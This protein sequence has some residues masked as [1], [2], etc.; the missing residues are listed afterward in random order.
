MLALQGCE[1]AHLHVLRYVL[2]GLAGETC[3]RAFLIVNLFGTTLV[4][5]LNHHRLRLRKILHAVAA[6][7]ASAGRPTHDRRVVELVSLVLHEL[8]QLVL[9]Q[10]VINLTAATQLLASVEHLRLLGQLF[11]C[12]AL[13]ARRIVLSAT[14]GAIGSGS[15]LLH[16]DGVLGGAAARVADLL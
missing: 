4:V 9:V 16:D 5:I 13:R 11:R 7:A 6:S 2:V 10:A 3:G 1:Q 12:L 8:H 14:A 15:V